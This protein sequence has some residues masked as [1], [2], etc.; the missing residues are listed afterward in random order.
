MCLNLSL[1]GLY[2]LQLFTSDT[3][4]IAWAGWI[5]EFP[6]ARIG[7]CPS[8]LIAIL[9]WKQQ[10]AWRIA[11]DSWI[12]VVDSRSLQSI[13]YLWDF[14]R[15]FSE[16][17]Y[18]ER[19]CHTGVTWYFFEQMSVWNGDW[20]VLPTDGCS[21]TAWENLMMIEMSFGG[22]TLIRK[23]WEMSFF[24]LVFFST[25]TLINTIFFLKVGHPSSRST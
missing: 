5:M 23:H 3:T 25:P 22:D 8:L 7:E 17:F 16:S 21:L 20:W 6:E 10:F 9:D 12:V 19:T 4:L 14:T 18:K 11:D 2:A 15:K 13:E 1:Y 24:C